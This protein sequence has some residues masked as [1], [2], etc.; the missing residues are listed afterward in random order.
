[1]TI[2]GQFFILGWG[3][4]VPDVLASDGGSASDNR[5]RHFVSFSLGQLAD[6][7]S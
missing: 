4:I 2:N 5:C 7:G 3:F 6:P 1:M